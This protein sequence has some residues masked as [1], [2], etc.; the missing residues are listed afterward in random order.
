[1]P[2]NSG[3]QQE[4]FPLYLTYQKINKTKQQKKAAI[5]L[6]Y[7]ID[8]IQGIFN[9]QIIILGHLHKN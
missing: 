6:Y 9:I 2:S 3:I 5:I 8:F 7:K 1:M 4:E